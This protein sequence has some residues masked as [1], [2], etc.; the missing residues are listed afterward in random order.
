MVETPPDGEP[1]PVPSL[2]EADRER[3]RLEEGY[4]F[5]IRKSLEDRDSDKPGRVM[6]FLNTSFGL[7]LLS[8]VFVTGLGAAFTGV[9]AHLD[10][11]HAVERK[12][13][14]DED[15]ATDQVDRLNHE[16]SYRIGGLISYLDGKAAE[17]ADAI[18]S[19]K[20][21]DQVT[22]KRL[23]LM[24]QFPPSEAGQYNYPMLSLYSENESKTFLQV[25]AD[26]D[27]AEGQLSRMKGEKPTRDVELERAIASV[28]SIPAFYESNHL[29]TEGAPPVEIASAI[30]RRLLLKRW[31]D[32]G[33]YPF[34]DCR[35]DKPFC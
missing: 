17:Q 7:W 13:Q 29:A 33:S 6:K 2:V 5:E 16:A 25:L 4:R 26:L 20:T 10:N 35:P 30:N 3:I 15:R 1:A 32:I 31:Q 14:D 21:P 24:L 18:K 22:A 11:S 12:H 34:T 19:G 8:T 28:S 9:K 23:G 27:R